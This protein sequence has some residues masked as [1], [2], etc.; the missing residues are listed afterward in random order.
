MRDSDFDDQ[1]RNL[2]QPERTSIPDAGFSQRVVAM[3]PK[4]RARQWGREAIIPGMTLVGCWLGLIVLPGGEFLHE[5]L[6]RLPHAQFI[7][8]LPVPWLIVVWTAVATVLE[9]R[10]TETNRRC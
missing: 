2:L 6:A 7:S 5:L 8:S 9:T 3:L 4:R 10:A 1:L